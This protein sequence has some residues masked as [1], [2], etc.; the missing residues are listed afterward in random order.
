[1][2]QEFH[3]ADLDPEAEPAEE[4]VDD[5]DDLGVTDTKAYIKVTCK[6]TRYALSRKSL[7]ILFATEAMK[8]GAQGRTKACPRS[9]GRSGISQSVSQV[10]PHALP[11]GCSMRRGTTATLPQG[12]GVL[13][14]LGRHGMGVR[15][16]SV[17][18][19]SRMDLLSKTRP[20][21]AFSA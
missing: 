18:Q 19:S 10:R 14:D 3:D 20:R 7:L 13:D 12:G 11:T 9:V 17:G 16:S 15:A 1:M 5:P 21:P 4:V 2:R 6:G 8:A